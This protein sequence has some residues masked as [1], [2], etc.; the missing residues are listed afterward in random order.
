M[1]QRDKFFVH[2]GLNIAPDQIFRDKTFRFVGN[3][4]EDIQICREFVGGHS[5]LSEICRRT[6]RFVG[7]LSEDIQICRKF[8]GYKDIQTCREFVGG[9]QICRE[10]V[11]G[12]QL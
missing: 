2:P 4:S 10:F 12:H 9:H 1:A 7:N 11:G 3:L 6:F 8:V 5:D